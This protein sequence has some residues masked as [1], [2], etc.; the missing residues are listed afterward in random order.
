VSASKA[1]AAA[2]IAIAF[3][4]PAPF[5]SPERGS[6]TRARPERKTRAPFAY[7]GFS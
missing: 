1:A 6:I 5:P 2:E 4:K 7:K 3:M